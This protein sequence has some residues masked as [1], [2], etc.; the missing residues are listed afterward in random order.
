VPNYVSADFMGTLPA[1]R[2]EPVVG[3][4][5]ITPRMKRLDLAIDLI[6]RLR[7][8]DPRFRLLVKGR[9][10]E[11]YAWMRNRPEEM[12]YYEAQYGRLAEEPSLAGAVEF[13]P[14]GDDMASFYRRIGYVISVSDHESFHLSLPDGAAAGALPTTLDWLGADRIYPADW[15]VGSIDAMARRILAQSTANE[16]HIMAERRRNAAW[17]EARFAEPVVFARIDACCGLGAI[18]PS[19]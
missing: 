3:L 17:V 12:A 7:Q 8:T 1:G 14:F 6:A 15:I 10:P 13:E 16:A 19:A 11:E 18:E 4:V 5:G 9:R 2:P